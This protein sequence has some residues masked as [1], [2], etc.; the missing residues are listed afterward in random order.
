MASRLD[1]INKTL[2]YLERGDVNGAIEYLR[3]AREIVMKEMESR[4]RRP[5]VDPII[6]CK[7][8]LE[9]SSTTKQ[10]IEEHGK[11]AATQPQP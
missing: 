4:A 5:R 11:E 3:L 1:I 6:R 8:L 10:K 2:E 9:G 7:E